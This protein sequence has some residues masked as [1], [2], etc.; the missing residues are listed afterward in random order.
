MATVFSSVQSLMISPDALGIT[1]VTDLSQEDMVKVRSVAL[2]E[3]TVTFDDHDI[4]L[5][6]RRPAR[7]KSYPGEQLQLWC[8]CVC[9]RVCVRA[10]ACTRAHVW[11]VC[12][13]VCVCVCYGPC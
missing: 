13:C 10:C 6:S 7:V 4:P 1:R 9:V 3:L 11:C 5:R 2:L 12:V 8:V